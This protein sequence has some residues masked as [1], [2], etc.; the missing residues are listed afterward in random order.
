MYILAHTRIKTLICAEL[1]LMAS[2]AVFIILASAIYG[3][4][5]DAPKGVLSLDTITFDKIVDGTRNVLVK[6]DK[7]QCNG[8]IP[9][10]LAFSSLNT[11]NTF[12]MTQKKNE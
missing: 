5:G 6:F 9:I 3:V 1:T 10:I 2:K 11:G 4:L 12:T 7:V 8:P